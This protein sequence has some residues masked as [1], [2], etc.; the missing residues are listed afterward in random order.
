[1]AK[2]EVSFTTQVEATI[3]IRANS[4]DDVIKLVERMNLNDHAKRFY[5]IHYSNLDLIVTYIGT[6][7]D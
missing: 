1:M 2:F 6:D 7:E 4:E 3:D 5:D